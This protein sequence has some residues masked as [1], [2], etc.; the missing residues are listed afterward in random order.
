MDG[1]THGSTPQLADV[2]GA[3][4]VVIGDRNNVTIYSY[5]GVSPDRPAPAPLIDSGGRVEFPYRG[6]GWFGE[7]DAP[8]FFGRDPEIAK[9]LAQLTTVMVEPRIIAVTGASG[10]GK[11]SLLRAGV[12]PRIRGG[13]LAGA[14]GA[15]RWPPFVLFSPGPSPLED[16][17]IATARATGLDAATLRRELTTDPASFAVIAAQAVNA[18]ALPDPGRRLLIV[19]DQFERVFAQCDDPILREGFVSA[20]NAAATR[21]QTETRAPAAI[22]LVVVRADFEARCAEIEGL[23]EAIDEHC[24]ITSMTERQLRLAITEPAKKAGSTVDDELTDQL[25]R[26]IRAAARAAPGTQVGPTSMSGAGV[27]PLVSDALDRAW[28]GRAG[29]TLTLADYDR[30]G[31]IEHAVADTARRVYDQLTV[32][33]Q[34][35]ARKVFTRLVVVDPEGIDTADRAKRSDL[36]AAAGDPRDAEA[37]LDAFADERLLTLGNDTVEVS[38]EVLVT[39]WPLLRDVWLAE[40]RADRA[41]RTALQAAARGWK[42]HGCDPAHLYTGSVLETATMM[43]A[44]TVADPDR[45]PPLSELEHAF[46]AASVRVSKRRDLQR[47]FATAILVVLVIGLAV[48]SAVAIQQTRAYDAQRR[49]A[50]ARE[51]ISRSQLTATEDPYTSR[52]A[53]LAAWRLDKTPAARHAMLQ[54]ATN[55]LGA[56]LISNAGPLNTVSFSSDEKTVATGGLDGTIRLWDVRTRTQTGELVTDSGVTIFQVKFSPDGRTLAAVGLNGYVQLW[57]VESRQPI[58]EALVGHSGSVFSASF[59]TDGHT[60]VTGGGDGEVRLWDVPSRVPLGGP[61]VSV[62]TPRVSSVAVSPDN[63]TLAA[64]SDDGRVLLWDLATRVPIGEPLLGH[65]GAASSAVFTRDSRVLATGGNDGSVRLWSVDTRSEIGSLHG[66]TDGIASLAISADDRVLAA[67]SDSGAI[68]LWDVATLTP[69]GELLRGHKGRVTSV[70]FDREGRTLASTG[71]DG[72]IRLWRVGVRVPQGAPLIGQGKYVALTV[73][74][75]DGALLAT[76][77][78]QGLVEVWNVAGRTRI[79]LPLT[80]NS[81]EAESVAFSPDSGVL[82]IGRNDGSVQL[83]EAPTLTSLGALTGHNTRVSSVLFSPNGESLATRD[84]SG[85]ILLWDMSS[86]VPVGGSLPGHHGSMAFSPDSSTLATADA[87]DPVQLWDVAKRTPRGELL[88]R[89]DSVMFSPDG[90]SLVTSGFNGSVQ[91][92]DTARRAPRGDPLVGHTMSVFS[93]VFSPDGQTLATGS[94]GG[95]VRLWDMTTLKPRGSSLPA[96]V[97]GNFPLAFRP[98]DTER[99]TD[100]VHGGGDTLVVGGDDES[101]ALW[102]VAT[103]LRVG[104]PMTGAYSAAFSPDGRVLATGRADGSIWLWDLAFIYDVTT[105][106]CD[107]EP[108]SFTQPLWPSEIPADLRPRLCP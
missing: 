30:V 28:R 93:M 75:P 86:R 24:M 36:I 66:R 39:A 71:I 61:L 25:L 80:D 106:L 15:D 85:S 26:E 51:L 10:A 68:E 16:L 54:A 38:H 104:D 88:P 21:P 2:R 8:L 44:R 34:G 102:D 69:I 82:A 65:V 48:A 62:H 37:V 72:T 12:L 7:H 49:S 90:Q 70:A 46:L 55:P 79:G 67:S 78:H 76:G 91:V 57:D 43:S 11:S 13:G 98:S 1:E 53:A 3:Q 4:G 14:V 89:A 59:S 52:L 27:L 23:A 105:V 45:H 100:V 40:T 6:L 33:Q 99:T 41:T 42:T 22:V 5:I 19:V 101:M 20:L 17:A 32:Q 84:D 83:W 60:L 64:T 108:N 56:V 58:G 31:G 74:S 81:G 87:D 107:E 96:R 47:R 35:V 103:G 77:N 63:R 50:V 97:M 95:S 73:F 9:V 18:N 94:F 29:E 92:W